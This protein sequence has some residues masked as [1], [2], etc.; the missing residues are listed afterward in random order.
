MPTRRPARNLSIRYQSEGF[1]PSWGFFPLADLSVTWDD[2]L[3]AAVTV[4]RPNRQY[5]F[6]HGASSGYEALFRWSLLRMALEERRDNSRHL[7]RTKAFTALDPTEKG[8]V[9]YFLGMTLCKLFAEKQ[10]NTPWLL[11]LDVFRDQLQ[12]ALSQR[13]R[14]DLIGQQTSTG[15]WFGFECKGRSEPPDA[16]VKDRAK[17]QAS[18]LKSVG[19]TPCTLHVGTITFFRGDNLEFC[20]LDPPE[21]AESKI[22]VPFSDDAWRLY[23]Q[24][25]VETLRS[26]D[27][28][29]LELA[30]RDGAGE[31]DVRIEAA[32]LSLGLH[33]RIANL[34]A[35]AE[36]AEA[37]R[38]AES[39]ADALKQEGYYPDGVKVVAGNSWSKPFSIPG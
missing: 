9:S 26:V 13:S 31:R 19:G 34:L 10:L 23:Y 18:R 8:A 33:P 37:K 20:W 30:A 4:G 17:A 7:S 25:V 36:W 29:L 32:D 2:L 3:H 14:P 5:V 21:S 16:A 6:Q 1:A 38:A 24:P 12:A 27:P 39:L 22:D 11:H 28:E 35:R 15:D